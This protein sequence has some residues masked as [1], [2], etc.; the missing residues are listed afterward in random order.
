MTAP[1]RRTVASVENRDRYLT[2]PAN[3]SADEVTTASAVVTTSKAF[4][5]DTAIGYTISE[6][7]GATSADYTAPASPLILLAGQS[8]ATLSIQILTDAVADPG[9]SLRI[10]WNS[11]KAL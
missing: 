7:G 2:A 8:S 10:N 9:E 5:T 1:P 3:F 6:L 4:P 11:V